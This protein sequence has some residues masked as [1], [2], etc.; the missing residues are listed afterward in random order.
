MKRSLL[1]QYNDGHVDTEL[2][3]GKANI[4]H[5]NEEF[6]YFEKMRDGKWRM[7]A[8]N[9]VIADFSKIDCLKVHRED[10][11]DQHY[12]RIKKEIESWPPWK[13]E[14]YDSLLKELNL[15]P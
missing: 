10:S 13:R 14:I 15:R 11:T 1:I 9:N 8:T 6:I 3:L 4:I 7:T 12:E 2:E 5:S